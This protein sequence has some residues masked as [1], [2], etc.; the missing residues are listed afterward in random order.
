VNRN[1]PNSSPFYQQKKLTE[2]ELFK[3][4]ISLDNFGK[5]ENL[6]ELS[7]NPP[8]IIITKCK[9]TVT[10]SQN[11]F[12]HQ[13]LE[14]KNNYV[15]SVGVYI[16]LRYDPNT[17]I[18]YLKPAE[19]QFKNV[20]KQY[21]GQNLDNKSLLIWRQGGIGDLLFIQPNLIYLKDKYPTCKIRFACGPQYQSMVRKWD[22]VDE[23]LDLP[24]HINQLFKSNFHCVFEG[25]IERC[26]EAE[27]TCS[28][29]LFTKW[30]NLNLPNEQLVPKQK[31]DPESLVKVK[32]V[33]E[34]NNIKEKDFIVLQLR[35]SSPIRTPNP[36][37]WI[38]L[39][40]TLT[41]NGHNVI[42][43]DS[44]IMSKQIDNFISTLDNNDKIFNFSTYSN[45]IADS[46]SLVSLA[47]L[48]IST[49]SALAHIAISVGTKI[50]GIF[51]PFPG[52]VRLSTYPKNMCDWI[53]VKHPEGCAP[54][55][56][57]GIQPCK[58]CI[59]NPYSPCYNY[60]DFDLSIEKIERLL[61][62]V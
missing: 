25:V 42:I 60:L 54:C 1:N 27:K 5:V 44:P 61:D 12:S 10:F 35:A 29:N 37:V 2:T 18:E 45:E 53:D 36:N 32:R 51:G 6:E 55:F 23:V 49:D 26:K 48:A 31:P 8:N 43:T 40:N 9:R 16:Q 30:M 3:L 38:K 20:Y 4:G 47:K 15:M 56:V 21:K 52:N 57:H 11:K 19:I 58:K 62:N 17:K 13:T 41:K 46:I 24:F 7:K 59:Q 33:L 50:F 22:C 28:Y 39:I 14:K 34:K